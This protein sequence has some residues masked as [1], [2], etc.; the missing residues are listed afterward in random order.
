[1]NSLCHTMVVFSQWIANYSEMIS[2]FV[3]TKSFSLAK[4]AE[5][6]FKC[7][8]VEMDSIAET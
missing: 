5:K 2:S 3:Q 4:I 8:M 6:A 7:I 1:M